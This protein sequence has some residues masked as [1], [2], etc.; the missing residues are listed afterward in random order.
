MCGGGGRG[1][2]SILWIMYEVVII[3]PIDRGG[4]SSSIFADPGQERASSQVLMELRLKTSANRR[5]VLS[6]KKLLKRGL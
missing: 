4:I 5:S 6:L 1:G 3:L 2:R